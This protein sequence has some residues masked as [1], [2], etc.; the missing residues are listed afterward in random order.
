M[1]VVFI[2]VTALFFSASSFAQGTL[3]FNNRT[4]TG[5]AP[6]S[7]GAGR[8]AGSIPGMTA[9]LYLVSVGGALTTPLY[10]TTSFRDSSEGAMFF[11]KEINPFAVTGVLPGQSATLRM[12]V[13]QGCSYE[14]AAASGCLFHLRSND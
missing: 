9:Q 12:V 5:A 11:V 10:P 7:V 3:V 2:L 1:K 14:A 4:P 8:G 13:Y 6:F